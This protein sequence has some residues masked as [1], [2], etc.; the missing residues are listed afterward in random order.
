MEWAQWT[1]QQNM[2]MLHTLKMEA[3]EGDD[4]LL[5]KDRDQPGISRE[6]MSKLMSRKVR[7]PQQTPPLLPKNALDDTLYRLS[8]DPVGSR[9]VAHSNEEMAYLE[10]EIATLRSE[11][12]LLLEDQSKLVGIIQSDNAKLVRVLNVGLIH[13]I[14]P[15]VFWIRACNHIND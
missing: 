12:D 11:R 6:K 10:A 5:G 15:I 9:E 13:T 2:E 8:E 4:K 14:R 7:T 3:F 1:H